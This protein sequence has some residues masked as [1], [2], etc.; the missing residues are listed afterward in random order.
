MM[1]L[2]CWGRNIHIH[3]LDQVGVGA[4]RCIRGGGFTAHQPLISSERAVGRREH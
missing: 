3:D 4:Y 2:I 1:R